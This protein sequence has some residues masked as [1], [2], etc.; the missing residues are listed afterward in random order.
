MYGLS[1]ADEVMQMSEDGPGGSA[2]CDQCR[3]DR[4]D[5]RGHFRNHFAR[6][7]PAGTGPVVEF[8]PPQKHEFHRLAHFKEPL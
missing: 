3:A 7:V 2:A 5:N 4:R 8:I 6:D 1:G